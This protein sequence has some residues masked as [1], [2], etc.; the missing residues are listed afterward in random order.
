MNN[1]YPSDDEPPRQAL[2]PVPPLLAHPINLRSFETCSRAR[3]IVA[4]HSELKCNVI[5]AVRCKSWACP[6]CSRTKIARLAAMTALAC[7]NKL[8]TLT[9]DPS[10]Y[11]TPRDAFERTTAFVPELIRALRVR[12]GTVEYLRVTEQTK[13]GFPHYHMMV[14]SEYLP[15]PVIRKLWI[16]YTGCQIVDV[17]QTTNHF[18]AY[19]YLVKYLTKL[20]KLDW[21]D[22][23]VSYSK[24]FFPPGCT[25]SPE[26]AKLTTEEIHDVHPWEYLAN[27]YHDCLL[28]WVTA[29][30]WIMPSLPNCPDEY[31]SARDCGVL[32]LIIDLPP[33]PTPPDPTPLLPH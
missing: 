21:T 8:L 6:P 24:A 28:P 11:P 7:P 14:R 22:R 16:K 3:T 29:N 32:P 15:Q 18:G 13:R 12:Y 19:Q 17:R 9:T 25:D 27:N 33:K 20:H 5:V 23:H 2:L 26:R 10:I 4:Y 31:V 30:S 1:H